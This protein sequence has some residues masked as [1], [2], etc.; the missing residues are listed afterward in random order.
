MFENSRITNAVIYTVLCLTLVYVAVTGFTA[1]GNEQRLTFDGR[2]YDWLGSRLKSAPLDYSPREFWPLV[3]PIIK[4]PDEN[5]RVERYLNVPLFK[6]PPMVPYLLAISKTFFGDDQRSSRY[7]PLFFRM[8]TILLVFYL[9]RY[10]LGPPWGVVAA[11]FM[12]IEPVSMFCSQKVWMEIPLNFFIYLGIY[13][14]FTDEGEKSGLVLSAVAFAFAL[15]CKYVAFL[16]M[17]PVYMFVVFYRQIDNRKDELIYLA[18][19]FVLCIPWF[20]WNVTVFGGGIFSKTV[21]IHS[22]GTGFAPSGFVVTALMTIAFGLLAVVLVV[23]ASRFFP[24][25]RTVRGIMAKISEWSPRLE[26]TVFFGLA[27]LVLVVTALSYMNVLRMMYYRYIPMISSEP[28]GYNSEPAYFLFRSPNG[29]FTGI[30]YRLRLSLFFPQVRKNS[31]T[32]HSCRDSNDCSNLLRG[33]RFL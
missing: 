20:I 18:A 30:S 10:L 29:T 9:A 26:K 22:S 31:K 17:I 25:N 3:S 24:E 14:L 1:M 21:E 27:L 16:A 4:N 5:A 8:C 2:L 12:A 23:F 32:V 6:H 7:V 28:H 15:W 11:I 19:P 33:V 13:F